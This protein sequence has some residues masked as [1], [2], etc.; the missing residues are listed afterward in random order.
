MKV[1]CAY[2]TK[3][4]RYLQPFFMRTTNEAI[5]AIQ[6]VVADATSNFN[7]YPDDYAFFELGEWDDVTSKF[8][9]LNAPHNLGLAREFMRAASLAAPE[10]V[11]QA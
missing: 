4:E 8:S 7:K 11:K 9:L 10:P 6:T 5:R 1:F 3:V 2:D